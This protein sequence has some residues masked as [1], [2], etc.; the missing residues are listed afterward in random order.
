MGHNY[1]L[2]TWGFP[3][4]NLL[5]MILACLVLQI[6]FRHWLDASKSIWIVAW[7]HGSV[8]A[9]ATFGQIFL[10][11]KANPAHLIFGPSPVGLL[12]VIPLAILA[13]TFIYKERRSQV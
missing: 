12:G 3:V 5:A 8:N 2:K 1:G 4:S 13:L 7:A 11:S 9:A 10:S 6:V